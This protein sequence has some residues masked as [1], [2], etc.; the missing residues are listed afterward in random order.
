M[1]NNMIWI[2]ALIRHSSLA[3]LIQWPRH[4]GVTKTKKSWHNAGTLC[5]FTSPAGAAS[6]VWW[7]STQQRQRLPWCVTH[8]SSNA[9]KTTM[10][11]ELR[12]E[13]CFRSPC[14]YIFTL[15]MHHML[16]RTS[17]NVDS[18]EQCVCVMENGVLF[19][20]DAICLYILYRRQGCIKP[21]IPDW[22]RLC[23]KGEKLSHDIIRCLG[24]LYWAYAK[25]T[26]SS[27]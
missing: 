22:K 9:L 7:R 14:T 19:I 15:I 1:T 16:M 25:L 4:I 12:V 24:L 6:E 2:L 5:A 11:V 13:L 21:Q 26:E 10:A 18:Y 3:P 27:C 23:R 17:H 20:Q 8:T